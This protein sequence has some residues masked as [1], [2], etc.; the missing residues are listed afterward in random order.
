VL[1][2]AGAIGCARP[3]AG[4]REYEL[5]R[6]TLQ[7][8]LVPEKATVMV[9]EPIFASFVVRNG[10]NEDLQLLAGGDTLNRLRRPDSFT[11]RALHADGAAVPTPDSPAAGGSSSRGPQRLSARG[12]YTFSLFLPDW[13]ELTRPGRYVITAA[14]TLEITPHGQDVDWTEPA[15]VNRLAV[16][17][18]AEV[19]VVPADPAGFGDVIEARGR[20]LFGSHEEEAR[21]AAKALAALDDRRVIP[22]L[23]HAV[24]ASPYTV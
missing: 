2:V 12:A 20:A 16:E 14:R 1:G 15:N 6:W 4:P 23:L 19:T 17:G 22:H 10:S 24:A 13:A 5:G 7:V 11:V 8:S 3:H 9:G 18:V 21:L